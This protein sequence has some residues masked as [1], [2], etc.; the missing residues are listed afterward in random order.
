VPRFHYLAKDS[1]GKNIAE[2]IEAFDKASLIQQLQQKGYFI[3]SVEEHGTL[4]N[5][6]EEKPEEPR[7]FTHNNIKLMDLLNF[8]N[9]LATMLDSGITILR[10]L[11]VIT[12]QVESKKFY[13]VLLKVNAD[14]EQGSS[15]SESLARFPKVFNQLWVSLI[16]VGEAS[17]TMPKV[18]K[19]LA[20]YLEQ[21]AA[22]SSTVTSAV[23]YPA[24]LFCVCL[25]AIAF[26]A[27]F[28][29]PRFESIFNT[30]KVD[31]PLITRMLLSSFRFIKNN[32]LFIVLGTIAVIFLF[33]KYSRTTIGRAH[34]EQFIFGMPVFGQIAKLIVIER[35]S[36]QMS[37]LVD[38]GVPILYALDITE[39]LVDNSICANVIADIKESVRQGELLVAPMERS[40]FFPSM[41]TQ[42]IA[43]GEETGELSKMLT[44][45]A[46]YYQQTV[47][48]FMKRLGTLIEPFML[49]FM[50]G[51]IGVIVLAM[52]LPMFNI[53]Q[54][55]GAGGARH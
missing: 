46:N 47:E 18:L 17:G 7:K 15:L 52:F 55:G 37:I 41:C 6:I 36:S 28:V 33:R 22:F 4:A 40:K 39:R 31:L 43:V 9:Q 1:S 8:A 50:G 2:D 53:A 32:F 44:H 45:V 19:K 21:K 51:V 34:V 23:M 54:L 27:L 20:F 26:F 16:E 3:L 25:G 12:D 42:M 5:E 48:T 24:V 38:S 30:M 13:G 14:V 29:G 10:A 11:E 49:V 35:F